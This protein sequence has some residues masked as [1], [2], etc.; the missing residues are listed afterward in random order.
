LT[1]LVVIDTNIYISAIFWEG[2]PRQVVDLGRDEKITI[3]TSAAIEKEIAEKLKTK[4]NLDKNEISKILADFS[5][6]TRLVHAANRI[7]AVPDDP[8]YDKIIECAVSGK[9]DYIVS[10][11]RHLLK[12]E[13]YAGITILNAS[14][15]LLK[16]RLQ[17]IEQISLNPSLTKE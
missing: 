11:D 17:D 14:D 4:F 9:A 12:L 10:G 2:K 1:A 5:T 6:F 16:I 8:D 7:R 13:E 15:F 3:L